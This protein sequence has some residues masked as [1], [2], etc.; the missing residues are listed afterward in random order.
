MAGAVRAEDVVPI[1]YYPGIIMLIKTSKMATSNR[2]RERQTA[3]G[4]QRGC[5]ES[6]S[7]L[8]RLVRCFRGNNNHHPPLG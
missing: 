4:S 6:V 3:E 5:R 7:P 8:S 1:E 2:R